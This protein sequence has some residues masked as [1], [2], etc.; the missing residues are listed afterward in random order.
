MSLKALV[1]G[2]I[3]VII[4]GLLFQLIFIMLDVGYNI[5]MKDY[6]TLKEFKQ[7]FY[8]VIGLPSF[9][10]IMSFAGYLT[11]HFAQKNIE[12]HTIFVG[13]STCAFALLTSVNEDEITLLGILFVIVGIVF[14]VVG[15]HLWKKN[16][17]IPS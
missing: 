1:T 9:F 11:S 3:T 4:L 7:L 6:P 13:A 2:F 10:I 14:T 15:G 5:L 8:Y 17:I 16:N 12:A